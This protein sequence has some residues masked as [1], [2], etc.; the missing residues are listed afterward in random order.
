[1]G[2][3]PSILSSYIYTVVVVSVIAFYV[4]VGNR[5]ED[6]DAPAPAPIPVPAPDINEDVSIDFYFI[7]NNKSE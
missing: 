3:S 4:I 5:S 2:L 6:E 7:S 1:M